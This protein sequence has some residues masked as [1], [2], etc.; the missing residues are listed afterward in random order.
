M[1]LMK[2]IAVPEIAEKHN[3]DPSQLN[4]AIKNAKIKT[5]VVV[6]GETGKSCNAISSADLKLLYKVMPSLIAKE[7]TEEVSVS[8]VAQEIAKIKGNTPDIS[9]LLKKCASRN[10]K[11]IERKVNGRLVKCFTQKD[12]QALMKEVSLKKVA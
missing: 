12:Y 8:Q 11:L 5:H 9:G 4:K 10:I 1:K 6:R 3:A 2:L 7:A